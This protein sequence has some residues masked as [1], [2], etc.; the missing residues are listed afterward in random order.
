MTSFLK[1]TSVLLLILTFLCPFA[2]ADER[3]DLKDTME[4][5]QNEVQ[6]KYDALVLRIDRMDK[7]DPKKDGVEA[8]RKDA[9]DAVKR[10]TD[11][12]AGSYITDD[13]QISRVFELA[14][15][16]ARAAISEANA[17]FVR[18]VM[19]GATNITGEGSVPEGDVVEDFIPQF[20][21]L[22]FRFA[23]M[24]V[25]V[26]FVVSGVMFVIAFS[27]DERLGRAKSMLYYTLIGF[28][29]VA[30]AF[31]IVKAVTDIDFFGFI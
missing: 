1:K 23:S 24:A 22:L 3:G 4:S 29:F 14:E 11:L 6:G 5:L 9:K 31:A 13:L 15:E 8:Y 26:A 16:E 28:A 25:F 7:N 18:P 27:N 17:Y 12:D 20:I 10:F 2:L 19:P 30:L 21:R